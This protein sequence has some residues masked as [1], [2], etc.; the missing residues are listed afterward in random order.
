MPA[1]VPTCA[2][3]G[4]GAHS[5]QVD[6]ISLVTREEL[7]PYV[8]DAD[9]EEGAQGQEVACGRGQSGGQGAAGGGLPSCHPSCGAPFLWLPS[10][11]PSWSEVPSLSAFLLNACMA[12]DTLEVLEEDACKASWRRYHLSWALK[13]DVAMKRKGTGRAD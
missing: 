10:C 4:H 5:G 2:A 3:Q 11:H 12:G 9:E 1:P 7:Q 8:T 13:L 6:G